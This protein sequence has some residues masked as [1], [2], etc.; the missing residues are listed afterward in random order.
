VWEIE[1]SGHTDGL[2]TDPT[3]WED[4]VVAFLDGQL[5]VSR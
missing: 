1:G 5:G 3:G 2:A 4:R